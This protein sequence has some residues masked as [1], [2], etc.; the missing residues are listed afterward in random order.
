MEKANRSA[1]SRI[2]HSVLDIK[3]WMAQPPLVDQVRPAQCPCCKAA[4]RPVGAK[5]GLWGHGLRN[6]QLR[7]PLEP[8]GPAQTVVIRAR[9]YL[10][11]NCGAVLLVVPPGVLP[12]RY[13]TSSAIAL[14]M[15]L[16]GVVEQTLAAVRRQVSPW[17]LIGATAH[18][19][20]VTLRRWVAAVRDNK[21]FSGQIRPM[22]DDWSPRQVCERVATTMASLGPPTMRGHPMTARAFAGAAHGR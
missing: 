19:G 14:A 20:W 21:L 10:C 3:S 7:G 22:P 18:G 6:R 16:Y 17:A 2:V 12:T 4:G 11:R 1:G 9:R 5:L 15:A 8:D 13:Y